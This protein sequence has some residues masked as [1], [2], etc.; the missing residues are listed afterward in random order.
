MPDTYS[1]YQIEDSLKRQGVHP[2]VAERIAYA[3]GDQRLNDQG[4]R[5]VN[6]AAGVP[7]AGRPTGDDGSIDSNLIPNFLQAAPPALAAHWA[8]KLKPEQRGLKGLALGAGF[9]GGNLM[10]V[11]GNYYDRVTTPQILA[12]MGG[13]YFGDV[14]GTKGGEALKLGAGALAKKLGT[15]TIGTAVGRVAGMPLGPIGSL[16]L[17]TLGGWLLPKLIPGG[18]KSVEEE[19]AQGV[20]TSS[21]WPEL[22]GG[23]GLYVLANN[24]KRIKDM[25]NGQPEKIGS[26]TP[27]NLG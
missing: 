26:P 7:N 10:P 27:T 25:F 19:E 23:A 15:G 24:R 4:V 21:G 14:L 9:L 11:P 20:D 2:D 5:Q 18:A 1:S 6:S 17:G 8:A 3:I 16:A 13:S 22:T 12:D